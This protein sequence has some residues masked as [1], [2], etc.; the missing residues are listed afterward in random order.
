M[1]PFLEVRG[2]S[3]RFGA[4]LALDDVS[5]TFMAGKI[6]CVLGENGAGK[7][8]LG[9]IIGGVYAKD[10]GHLLLEGREV[11]LGTVMQARENGVAVVFQELSMAPD[12]SVRA[13]LLLGAEPHRHPFTRIR[14]GAELVRVSS[15]LARLDIR[16][17]PEAR[18][19]QL[20]VA[21]RQLLEVGKA[22][23]RRPRMIVLDEPTAMLNETEKRKLYTVLSS[24]R[25][26][27]TVVALI[28]HHLDD[29]EAVADHVS[30]MRDGRMV[31]SFAVSGKRET[32]LIAQKLKGAATRVPDAGAMPA[33]DPVPF[34]EI[35]GLRDRADRPAPLTLRRGEIV[36][37]YGV[38]GS[39][40]LRVSAALTGS[41]QTS[42]LEVQIDGMRHTIRTPSHARK[43]GIAYL[44]AGRASNGI[45]PT[46]SIRENLNIAGLSRY[47]R[48]GVISRG[49]E[50]AGTQRQLQA[51][52]VKY[53]NAED[54]ISLLSGG[55]QQKVLV[56]RVLSAATRVLVLEDPTAGVDIGAKRQI[57]DAIRTRASGGLAVI[58]VSSD[59]T[60]TIELVD[61]LYT[62]YSGAVVAR[63][64]SPE[65]RD[66][67]AI[68]A[69]IIGQ[70]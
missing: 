26:D 20:P 32:A 19:D 38:V 46:R 3:K 37:L 18:I 31:D 24:L 22:L 43:L 8:T 23:I 66:K 48:A 21:T 9:K 49:L 39:G 54:S 15:V 28:T 50:A 35:Q 57:L 70:N 60:E 69:D 42:T 30:I 68:V 53:A 40:A 55:N 10:T 61:T 12:L 5:A 7:S 63:Y 25:A 62:L 51:S 34:L 11:T 14:S 44:P 52:A 64:A 36:G 13:N 58:L 45:L 56:A 2:V 47:A 27:G 4:T 65:P 16:V 33:L 1:S 29:V 41:H 67:P 6:H 17:D 59:L